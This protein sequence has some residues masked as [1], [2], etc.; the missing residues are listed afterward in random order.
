MK[1][2]KK[3]NDTVLKNYFARNRDT[4]FPFLENASSEITRSILS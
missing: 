4:Y 2:K 3:E 1:K